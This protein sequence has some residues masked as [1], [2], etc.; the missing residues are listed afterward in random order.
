[1]KPAR[2]SV[3]VLCSAALGALDAIEDWQAID[4][5]QKYRVEDSKLTPLARSVVMSTPDAP[6]DAIGPF[7]TSPHVL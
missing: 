3:A 6:D 1:M 2:E 7:P 5:G 4:L